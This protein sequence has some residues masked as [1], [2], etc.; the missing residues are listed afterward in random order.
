MQKK[1]AQIFRVMVQIN[2]TQTGLAILAAKASGYLGNDNGSIAV[3]ASKLSKHPRVRAYMDHLDDAVGDL[4]AVVPLTHSEMKKLAASMART[5]KG[6]AVRMQAVQ[7]AAKLNDGDS[8]E[9]SKLTDLE[10]IEDLCRGDA[11]VRRVL[12][13]RLGLDLEEL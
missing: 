5:A 9:F 2:P 11:H 12:S 6:E 3:E 7:I 13:E 4:Q 1:F 10:L 8:E